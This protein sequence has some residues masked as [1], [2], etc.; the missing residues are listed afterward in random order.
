MTVI[1]TLC[2]V[3]FGNSSTLN[4]DLVSFHFERDR[5]VGFIPHESI[6]ETRPDA[7]FVPD[8]W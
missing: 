7:V 8:C 6:N 5:V 2:V 1:G 4:L 3:P